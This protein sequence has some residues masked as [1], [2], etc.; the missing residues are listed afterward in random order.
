[1]KNDCLRLS[2]VLQPFSTPRPDYPPRP[3]AHGER[4]IAAVTV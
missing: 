1:M 2:P 4:A 3:H